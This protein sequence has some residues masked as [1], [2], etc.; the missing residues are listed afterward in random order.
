MNTEDIL[1]SYNSKSES[2]KRQYDLA[3]MDIAKRWASLSHCKKK[4]VGAIIVKDRMIISDGFN[5]TPTGF[6]NHCEDDTKDTHWYTLHAE[7]NAIL[8]LAASTQNSMGATLYITCSPCRECSKL[9]YQSG[10]KRVVYLDNYKTFDGIEFLKKSGIQVQKM[11]EIQNNLTDI[12]DAYETDYNSKII[13]YIYKTITK[14]YGE[15]DFD[16]INNSVD[17]LIKKYGDDISLLRAFLI[18]T[19]SYKQKLDNRN[20][21]YAKIVQDCETLNIN[22][23]SYNALK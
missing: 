7:A 22:V 14:A 18:A 5:G 10:I 11:S 20:R 8:K 19:F 2:R 3:Y 4:Q 6:D 17:V 9:I 21:V 12:I 15:Q 13:L 23:D 1:G 16:S